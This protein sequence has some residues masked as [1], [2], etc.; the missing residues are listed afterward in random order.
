V[1]AEAPESAFLTPPIKQCALVVADL[2]ASVRR[3][4]EQ[5]AIGPWTG[6]RL[7]PP[8][9]KQM[10]YRGEDV[11]FSLRHALAWQGE[12]QFELV[13]PLDGPSIFSDHLRSHGEGLHHVGRYVSDHPAAT[14][15]ALAAGFV[16]L[17]SARGFGAEGDGAFAYFKHPHV[18]MIVEL[19][20]APRV[21]IEPEFVYPPSGD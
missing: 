21:R 3:W 13:Q 14:A 17:Q 8:L 15:A 16:E 18:A 19:I 6:Y 7:E 20:E 4:T 9:L 11:E 2:D 5:L 10:R 1:S 12:M